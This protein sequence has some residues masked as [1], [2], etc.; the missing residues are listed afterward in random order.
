MKSQQK[1]LILFDDLKTIFNKSKNSNNNESDSNNKNENE[2]KNENKNENES[3]NENENENDDEQCYEIKQLNIWFKTIDKIKSFKEQIL[4]T[5]YFLDGYWHVGCYHCDKELN[6]KIFK[7]KAAH[8]P[9]D[10]D[11]KLFEKI[12]GYTF[13]ALVEKLI[14]TIDKEENEII[15]DDIGKKERK[16]MN[17]I[18]IVNL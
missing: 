4:K 13:A 18:N 16:F 5:K 12:F 14:N 7:A 2:N 17:K 1:L 11:K 10:L 15:I 3:K 9:N 8:L 6:Y